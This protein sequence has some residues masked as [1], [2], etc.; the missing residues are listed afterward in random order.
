MSLNQ[1]KECAIM[2]LIVARCHHG[3]IIEPF[4][5]P[6]SKCPILNIPLH[7][8]QVNELNKLFPDSYSLVELTDYDAVTQIARQGS[9]T[10]AFASDLFFSAEFIVKF[11]EACEASDQAPS[12]FQAVLPVRSK[13]VNDFIKPLSSLPTIQYLDEEY[14]QLPLFYFNGHSFGDPLPIPIDIDESSVW[15][16]AL[17]PRTG[18][19]DDEKSA[20]ADYPV[21]PRLDFAPLR[22]SASSYVAIPIR[23]WVHVLTANIV[24]GL[25]SDALRFAKGKPLMFFQCPSQRN[26]AQPLKNIRDLILVGEGCQIDPTATLIGPIILGDNVLIGPRACVVASVI[27][28]DS[29]IEQGCH[30][31]LSVIGERTTFPP[32]LGSA[33]WSVVL[34][35]ALINS[36]LR[37]SVIGQEVFIGGGVWITDRV[38]KDESKDIDISYGGR[39]VCVLHQGRIVES[40][41]WVLGAAV[42]NRC[43]LGSGVVVLPGRIIPP[44][45]TIYGQVVK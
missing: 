21:L 16:L 13:T 15:Y 10:L 30:I 4:E 1:S 39:S 42:G 2:Q 45:R 27:G 41:Y 28:K 5:I 6:A 7:R 38:L 40:G 44:D 43:K 18:Y 37:F 25:F 22:V 19:A 29:V 3:E 23:H 24:F 35:N 8:I 14:C 26:P 11:L 12:A 32:P 33:L 34:D 36:P 20:F 31:R 9:P 17:P